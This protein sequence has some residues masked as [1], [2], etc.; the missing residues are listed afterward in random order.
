MA[1][2]SMRQLLDEAAEGG[3]GVGAF[4]VNMEEMRDFYTAAVR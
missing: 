3:C 4:T 1:M 2:V